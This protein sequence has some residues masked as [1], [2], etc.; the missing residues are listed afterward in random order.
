MAD[1]FIDGLSLLSQRLSEGVI[2]KEILFL[3]ELLRWN[4]QIN[5]T[6]IRNRN[7]AI[8]KH[9]LDSLLLLPHIKGAKRL[10]DIGS[11]GGL[12]GIPLAIAEPSLQVVSVDSVGK[13]INFQKHI[14][15]LLK[16]NN[17]SVIQSRIENL[18][19]INP[20]QEKYDLVV[21]RAFSS[22]DTFI[23]YADQWLK[24]GG[25]LLA[26]KGPEGSEELAAAS[27]VMVQYGFSDQVISTYALP[28]SHAERQLICLT[29]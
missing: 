23:P 8:E 2:E 29:R 13:K 14:K 17:L 18:L 9:L 5:L 28:F 26:M 15:R 3:D 6:S 10:L 21:S 16:L 12:P 4:Q 25:R 27:E 22:L 7:E 11:G 24:P 20:V 19:Q 1:C